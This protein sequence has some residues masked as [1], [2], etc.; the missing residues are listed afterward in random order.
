MINNANE[1]VKGQPREEEKEDH[2]WGDKY[3]K[4]TKQIT[5]GYNNVDRL[6]INKKQNKDKNAELIKWIKQQNFEIF[7]ISEV[8][9]NWR[10]S[11]PSR[12]LKLMA[13]KHDKNK[14]LIITAHNEH[15]NISACQWGGVGIIIR[16]KLVNYC[17]DIRTDPK[18]LGRWV[19][20]CIQGK[21][22]YKTRI[23]SAY[24]PNPGGGSESVYSQQERILPKLKD[25]RDPILAF[26]EDLEIEIQNAYNRKE[27]V[28]ILIDANDN[29]RK[30]K[31]TKR[32][33]KKHLKE[34]I[35]KNHGNLGPETY[36]DNTKRIPIDGIY[37]SHQLNFPFTGYFN[38]KQSFSSDHRVIWAAIREKTY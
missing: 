25:N 2:H 29:V 26:D 3:D 36:I 5:I 18:Q 11:N 7:G 13:Q 33:E 10:K 23:F 12:S 19:S 22:G 21:K 14:T 38:Y 28:I 4:K 15:E 9:I 27:A 37:A 6:W 17:H 16:G 1:V 8:G 32:L 31:V 34:I 24:R 20:L 30:G 35:L